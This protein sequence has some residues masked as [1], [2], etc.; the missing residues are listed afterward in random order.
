MSTAVA[1]PPVTGRFVWRD[2]MTNDPEKAKAFYLDLF[3]WSITSHDM[4]GGFTYEMLKNGE[5]HFGGVMPQDPSTPAPPQWISYIHVPSVDESVATATRLGGTVYAQPTDIPDV[6][7]FA[8]LGDPQGATFA[9][10]TA[11]P[12]EGDDGTDPGPQGMPP[13][14]GVTWNEL[15]TADVDAAKDF[16]GQVIG[17][18]FDAMNAMPDGT[19]QGYFVMKQGDRMDG[20]LMAKPAEL[21]VSL[22]VIYYHVAD[23]D[24]SLAEVARLGGQQASPIIEVPTI[25][26]M[27]WVTDPTGALFALHEGTK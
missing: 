10:L 17:W 11:L 27:A 9:L 23:I 5:E 1:A 14:G 26:R 24:A 7:R 18:R 8:I 13:L 20:G 25:G 12:R 22:W 3:G 16:Y 15:I 19:F 4:G 21:P 2:L 6:G